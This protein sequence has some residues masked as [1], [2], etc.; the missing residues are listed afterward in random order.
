MFDP[1]MFAFFSAFNN[2]YHIAIPFLLAFT[3]LRKKIKSEGWNGLYVFNTILFLTQLTILLNYGF[4]VFMAWYG[5]SSYEFFVFKSTYTG[6]L[7][8]V[9]FCLQFIPLLF[10]WRKLRV[11]R[12]FTIICYLCLSLGWV[13]Q[14]LFSYRRDYLE[15]NWSV[16]YDIDKTSDYILVYSSV[17]IVI[18]VVYFIGSKRKRLPY[19]GYFA[20]RKQA[21]NT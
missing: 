21:G 3:V 15:S 16:N 20:F 5:Q 10:Y 19:D 11:A 9:L 13:V 1:T 12:F 8:L 17:F 7:Y 2:V 6:S 18:V 14:K 4:T